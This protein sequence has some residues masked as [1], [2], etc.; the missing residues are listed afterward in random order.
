ML[1]TID[2]INTVQ[3]EFIKKHAEEIIK[4]SLIYYI[5]VTK[6]CSTLF[7]PEDTSG[8][9]LSINTGF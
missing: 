9:I 1:N 2:S 8:F 7:N 4:A 3:L 6:L 5:K